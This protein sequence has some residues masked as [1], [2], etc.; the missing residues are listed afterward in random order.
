MG[1]RG[2][3]KSLVISDLRPLFLNLYI[4]SII[5]VDLSSH[6]L[7]CILICLICN[8]LISALF[9][10]GSLFHIYLFAIH[11]FRLYLFRIRSLVIT[12]KTPHSKEWGVVALWGLLFTWGGN[13]LA[14]ALGK[15]QSISV[16]IWS[17]ESRLCDWLVL[18][19]MLVVLAQPLN[20]IYLEW[21]AL[22]CYVNS[23]RCIS[24]TL[25]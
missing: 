17:G 22:L 4:H 24:H 20:G 2:R 21:I 16:L 7:I 10:S 14:L 1:G 18:A 15:F 12:K 3:P 23:I 13:L 6:Y 9:I 25:L 11:L 5:Y 8:S 19:S